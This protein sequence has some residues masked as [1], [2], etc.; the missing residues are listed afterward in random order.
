M[1]A[2]VLE[3]SQSHIFEIEVLIRPKIGRIARILADCS[4]RIADSP[5]SRVAEGQI[6]RCAT[7]MGN[8][9]GDESVKRGRQMNEVVLSTAVV[10]VASPVLAADLKVV[11]KAPPPGFQASAW[12]LAVGSGLTSDYIFPAVQPQA[13]GQRLFRATL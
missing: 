2:A 11:T 12:D 9:R 6:T 1:R 13:F 8:R 4:H 7:R 10:V 5:T 3:W